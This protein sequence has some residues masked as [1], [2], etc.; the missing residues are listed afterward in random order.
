MKKVYTFFYHAIAFPL[1]ALYL[2]SVM[3][4]MKNPLYDGFW[5]C[6]LGEQWTAEAQYAALYNLYFAGAKGMTLDWMRVCGLR[7]GNFLLPYAPI[8]EEVK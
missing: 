4:M 7:D 6:G 3:T 8:H 5:I 2:V 1:Q